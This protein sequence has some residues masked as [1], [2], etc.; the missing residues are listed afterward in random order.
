MKLLKDPNPRK[1]ESFL[2]K[3]PLNEAS[4]LHWTGSMWGIGCRLSSLTAIARI[5]KLKQRPEKQGFIALIPDASVLDQDML[6]AAL[7]PLLAQ[8]WPGNLSVVFNYPDPQ[9]SH[10]A[11]EGKVAF[12]V[13]QDPMLRAFISLLGEP[14]ISTSVNISG[15]LPEEDQDRILKN[16]GSWFDVAL[17]PSAKVAKATKEH[18][19]LVEYIKAN[20]A[21]S[22]SHQDE[23][24]C[25]REGS[26]PFYEVKQSFHLPTVMFVCTANICR[27]PIA[28]KLFREKVAKAGLALASDSCGLIE[29]GHMISLNSLQLLLER[30][31]TEA[32][33]HVSKQVTPQMVSSSWLIL[34][35]E[36][37]QRDW[38]RNANPNAN[39]KIWTLNEI[40]GE[41]GDI[42]DPFGS[43]L[44]SYRKTF[45]LIED[46]LDRLIEK[47]H[48]NTIYTGN[49]TK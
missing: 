22:S 34:T 29:G 48:N 46:R 11:I 9:F 27:S 13:P 4:I 38:L 2:V 17:L 20:E 49:N 15:L 5:S 26:V 10:I 30:G 41:E 6:P 44:D 21:K 8:Y 12:R 16:F 25:L 47:I 40:V 31:I 14:L 33:N 36:E 7:K 32:Q 37:R 1:L 39:N 3:N 24:K 28:E 45:V 35:M 19:T 18:S 42:K 23:L 43:E